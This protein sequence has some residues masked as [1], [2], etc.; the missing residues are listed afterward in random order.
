MSSPGWACREKKTI[1]D[2]QRDTARVKR[3]RRA[4]VA[5]RADKLRAWWARL[6]F[7]DEFGAHWGMTRTYG[8]AAPGQRVVEGTPDYSGPH[9]TVVAAL[10]LTGIKA[11]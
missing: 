3:A 5:Y 1:H 8:R 11:P 2:S 4:F 6:H 9:Y 7:L 10:G